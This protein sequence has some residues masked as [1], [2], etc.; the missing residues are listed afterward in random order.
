MINK[1]ALLKEMVAL[2]DT[3]D[4][5]GLMKEAEDVD[6]MIDKVANYPQVGGDQHGKNKH[7]PRNCSCIQCHPKKASSDETDEIDKTANYPQV[8]GDQHG[9]N[10]HDPRNCSC[11]QCHPPQQQ[12]HRK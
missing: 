1:Q 12:Q 4:D 3:L 6:A 9:K 7:D 10:K 8:G 5:M 2:A 11:V